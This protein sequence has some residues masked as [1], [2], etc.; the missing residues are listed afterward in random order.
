MKE[1]WLYHTV[2]T[3]VGPSRFLARSTPL[4]SQGVLQEAVTLLGKG[5]GVVGNEMVRKQQEG[6]LLHCTR[7]VRAFAATAFRTGRSSSF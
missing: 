1:T 6:N 4:Y 7:A 3:F 5:D 2:G